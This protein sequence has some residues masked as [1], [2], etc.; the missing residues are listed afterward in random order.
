MRSILTGLVLAAL[1]GVAPGSVAPAHAQ[2]TVSPNDIQRLQDNLLDLNSDLARLRSRGADEAR[3]YQDD[4]DEV[5]DEVIYLRV[6][7]RK[8]QTV[9]RSE[10]TER[11]RPAIWD[12]SAGVKGVRSRS[13]TGARKFRSLVRG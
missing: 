5:R 11:I 8:G 1:I 6:K 10:Y 3:D 2:N 7:L 4:V 9:S 12:I 13:T